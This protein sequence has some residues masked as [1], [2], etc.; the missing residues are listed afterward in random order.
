MFLEG[1]VH[2]SRE[3]FQRHVENERSSDDE[4]DVD[5]VD[6]EAKTRVTLKQP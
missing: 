5:E 2:N 6:D 1:C 3:M 4:G